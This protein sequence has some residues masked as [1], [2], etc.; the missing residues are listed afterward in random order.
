MQTKAEARERA[1][2]GMQLATEK[3]DRD[4]PG[5]SDL[6]YLALEKYCL[7]H[8]WKHFLA[9][10]VREWAEKRG[11]VPAPENAKA[12]GSV[13]VRAKKEGLIDNRGYAPANSSN[14]SPKTQWVS[15]P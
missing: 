14:R 15:I 10:D 2:T 11:M 6:A 1:E 5:W 3:A 13:M 12:W 4:E 8:P 7:A 9:E